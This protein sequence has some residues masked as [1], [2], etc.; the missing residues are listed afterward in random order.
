MLHLSNAD[1]VKHCQRKVT[2][3]SVTPAAVLFKLLCIRDGR[4]SNAFED[5]IIMDYTDSIDC[6]Q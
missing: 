6:R 3:D 4:Y 1:T 5:S 2:A